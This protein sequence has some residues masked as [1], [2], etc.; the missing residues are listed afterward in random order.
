[1]RLSHE[2]S[3]QHGYRHCVSIKP[4][5]R[6]IIAR[7]VENAGPDIA[8]SVESRKTSSACARVT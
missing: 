6:N 4:D 8:V 5:Q 1:M 7:M 2:F 3:Q